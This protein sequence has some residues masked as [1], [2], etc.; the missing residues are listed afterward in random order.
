M[1]AAFTAIEQLGT[2]SLPLL[3]AWL[4]ADEYVFKKKLSTYLQTNNIEMPF[5]TAPKRRLALMAFQQIPQHATSAIPKMIKLA[6][7]D[8]ERQLALSTL[9]QML[10]RMPFDEQAKVLEGAKSYT[11]KLLTSMDERGNRWI[12]ERHLYPQDAALE[13]C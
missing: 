13:T 11:E 12:F 9:G 4:D 2:N 5:L 8:K 10:V 3:L 7:E 1:R 6:I